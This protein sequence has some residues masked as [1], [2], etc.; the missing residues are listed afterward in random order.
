MS[1]SSKTG[2]NV[3]KKV[4]TVLL[5]FFVSYANAYYYNDTV[6]EIEAKVYPKI[7]FFDKDYEK[8]LV[9]KTVILAILYEKKDL[10]I[11]RKMK[12]FI[13]KNYGKRILEYPLKVKMYEYRIFTVDIPATAVI[14]LSGPKKEL[15]RAAKIA[16]LKKILSFVYDPLYLKYGAMI[17]LNIGRDIKPLLNACAVK[18]AGIRLKADFVSICKIYKR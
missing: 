9:N 6:V 15:I 17:S 12:K 5:L 18:E 10:Y 2:K 3:L 4:I 16:K 1:N 11:A 14:F 13:E 8:K 7:I